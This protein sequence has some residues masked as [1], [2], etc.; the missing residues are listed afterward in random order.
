[1]QLTTLKATFLEVITNIDRVEVE[2]DTCKLALEKFIG[3]SISES[4]GDEVSAIAADGTRKQMPGCGA[5]TDEGN[6]TSCE[7]SA[8]L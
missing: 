6:G 1:M 7:S 3:Q 5:E 4:E 2:S 8:S